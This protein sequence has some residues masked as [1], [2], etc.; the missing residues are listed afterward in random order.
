MLHYNEDTVASLNITVDGDDDD[1]DVVED[2]EKWKDTRAET[3]S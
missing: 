2:D 1:D 3:G